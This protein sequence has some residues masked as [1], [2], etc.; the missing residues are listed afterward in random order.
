MEDI[1]VGC[2][3][4]WNSGI[5][6]LDIWMESDGGFTHELLQCQSKWT[7]KKLEIITAPPPSLSVD[8]NPIFNITTGECM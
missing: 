4:N 6:H 8:I 5:A 3:E 7:R 2:V 1:C